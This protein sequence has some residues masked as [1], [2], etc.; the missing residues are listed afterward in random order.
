MHH[1]HAR[2]HRLQAHLVAPNAASHLGRLELQQLPLRIGQLVGGGERAVGR[3]RHVA[4]A[5][6]NLRLDDDVLTR[7]KAAR[8]HPVLRLVLVLVA[9][10]LLGLRLAHKG[11]A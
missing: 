8:A 6:A 5:I 11:A 4:E 9:A 2:L 7:H 10:A 1:V 3:R